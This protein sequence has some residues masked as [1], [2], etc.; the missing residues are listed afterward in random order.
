MYADDLT[1]YAKINSEDDK[2]QLQLDL[3]NFCKWVCKWQL[4]I[5]YEKCAVLHFGRKNNNVVYNLD[6]NIIASS[7]SEK[8]LDVVIDTITFLLNS[9]YINVWIKLIKCITL[10]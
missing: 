9:I 5:N 10:F 2:K 7:Q 6:G 1:T 3:N 4:Y 8:I